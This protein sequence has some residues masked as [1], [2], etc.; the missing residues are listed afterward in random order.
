MVS[1]IEQL[2]AEG[3]RELNLRI[4]KAESL[5][6][7][8]RAERDRLLSEIE[9]QIAGTPAGATAFE[10]MLDQLTADRTGVDI[11]QVRL[12]RLQHEQL[13]ES[14]A[15][16]LAQDETDPGRDFWE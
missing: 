9:R 16:R 12:A 5:A 4:G 6:A 8:L 11:D 10:T 3:I 1:V 2:G 15:A 7:M 13:E 14:H